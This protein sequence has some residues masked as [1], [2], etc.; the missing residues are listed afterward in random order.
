[1]NETGTKPKQWIHKITAEFYSLEEDIFIIVTE[2]N[3]VY[4]L[5][6][7]EINFPKGGLD[8]DLND[9]E[10]IQTI[11]FELE[12]PALHCNTPELAAEIEIFKKLELDENEQYELMEFFDFCLNTEEYI[13]D[14]LIS[15]SELNTNTITVHFHEPAITSRNKNLLE[16]DF[17]FENLLYAIGYYYRLPDVNGE[18]ENNELIDLNSWAGKADDLN[19]DYESIW[20][21]I[22][23]LLLE[24]VDITGYKY[25]YN[26]GAYHRE[27]GHTKNGYYFST[28]LDYMDVSPIDADKEYTQKLS[29]LLAA[30]RLII[31]FLQHYRPLGITNLTKFSKYIDLEI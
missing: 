2:D 1:M 28:N 11:E 23:D 21:K 5:N 31:Y 15:S 6:E 8:L 19:I 30:K 3:K 24:T 10:T 7:W 29:K 17:T 16:F 18:I 27:S 13:E 22:L 4:A 14:P 20:L 25:E 26:D 12:R 9:P